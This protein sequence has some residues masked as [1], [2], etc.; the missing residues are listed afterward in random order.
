MVHLRVVLYFASLAAIFG[1]FSME[2][3]GAR[4]RAIRNSIP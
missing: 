4:E 1:G 2:K 3:A